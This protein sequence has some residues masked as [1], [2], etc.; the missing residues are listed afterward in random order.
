MEN[1]VRSKFNEI[2]LSEIA[3]R[4]GIERQFLNKIS[5]SESFVY[6]FEKEGH[7][8][9][10][11]ITHNS[12]RSYQQIRAELD[13]IGYL[14]ANGMRV[15][16]PVLSES[17][18]T[19]ETVKAGNSEFLAVVFEKARG[20]EIKRRNWTGDFCLEWGRYVGR[21]HTLIHFST[22]QLS[23]KRITFTH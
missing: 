19:I 16:R 11:R 12:H 21:L 9:I 20:E 8:F 23:G 13:W 17:G 14:R 22:T 15:S 7:E 4:I 5:D 18:N 6:E 1:D 10:L 3:G 2:I